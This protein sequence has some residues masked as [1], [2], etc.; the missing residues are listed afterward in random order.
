MRAPHIMK[1]TGND[2]ISE[3]L[4]LPGKDVLL[5]L[6]TNRFVVVTSTRAPS[7]RAVESP[8][9]VGCHSECQKPEYPGNVL[10]LPPLKL[11]QSLLYLVPV[12]LFE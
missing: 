5:I 3:K 8:A 6:E 1:A 9:I 12:Y 10:T 7:L 4:E 11:L 2:E